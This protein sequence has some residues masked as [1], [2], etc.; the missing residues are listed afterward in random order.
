MTLIKKGDFTGFSDS[1][2]EEALQ[3]A[4]QKVGEHSH[5]E[6]IETLGSVVDES[7]PLYQIIIRAFFN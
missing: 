5:F 6:I 4:L 7:K 2:L 3:N 1:C